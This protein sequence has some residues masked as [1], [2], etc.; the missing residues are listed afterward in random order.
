MDD[1]GPPGP[2]GPSG[3]PA[4]RRRTRHLGHQVVDYGV[5]LALIGAYS[6]LA[7]SKG[8]WTI[9]LAGAVDLGLGATLVAPLAAWPRVRPHLH[10]ILEAAFGVG[11]VAVAL[12]VPL[13]F[14]ARLVDLL[15]AALSLRAA[16]TL[17]PAPVTDGMPTATASASVTPQG[18]PDPRGGTSPVGT[19]RPIATPLV[20]GSARA[21]GYLAGKARPRR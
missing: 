12:L 16:L 4:R 3:P 9:A 18:R 5:G 19:R 13:G 10:R 21:L 1:E 15:A 14:E 8:A 17:R 20:A 7:T 6:H 11:L 2:P